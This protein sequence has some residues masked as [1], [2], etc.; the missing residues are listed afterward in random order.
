MVDKNAVVDFEAKWKMNG[1]PQ[2]LSGS[3]P[4][5]VQATDK[6]D[7]IM[8]KA[9]RKIK[10][11]IHC[12]VTNTEATESAEMDQSEMAQIP[13]QKTDLQ[14]AAAQVESSEK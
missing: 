1:T 6:V 7:G 10:Y 2:N 5:H 14:E 3:V 13:M 9:D 4:I 11:R 12:Q 8:G